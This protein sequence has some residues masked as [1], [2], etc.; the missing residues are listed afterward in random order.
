MNRHVVVCS[1]IL[2]ILLLVCLVAGG[3]AGTLPGGIPR[4]SYPSGFAPGTRVLLLAD[5]PGVAPELQAGMAGTIICCDADDCSGSLLVSWDLFTGGRD[6]EAQCVTA[7]VGLYPSGSTALVDPAQV[8]LGQPFDEIGILEEDA[9]GCLYLATED[10]RVFS[11]VIGPEFREQWKVVRAGNGVRI[12]GWVNMS[13]PDPKAERLCLQRDGDIYHPIMSVANWVDAPCCDRWVCGFGCGDRV[14]LI[15]K[16]NPYGAVDL[17]RGTTGTVICCRYYEEQSLLISWNLWE[18]G[19]SDD[20]YMECNER[21]SG[22]FPPGSTSWVS[23]LDVAKF[24]ESECGVLEEISLC[25]GN[26]CLD[27]DAV[28]LYAGWDRLYYL[29][30]ADVGRPLPSDLHRAIGLLTP[31]TAALSGQATGS[32]T[33]LDQGVNGI[34][35]SSVLIA[36]PEPSCCE[37]PYVR[38]DRVELLVDQPGGAMDLFAGATG[39][40]I[41]CNSDDPITPILVSWDY[42]AGGHDDDEGCD[43]PPEW[44]PDDSAWWMAC[45]EIKPIVLADLYDIGPGRF[46]P[47]S[48]QAGQ[49]FEVSSLIGNRGG[50]ESGPVF[51][52]VYL[53]ADDQITRDDFLLGLGG[54][55][56]DPGGEAGLSLRVSFPAEIPPGVYYVGWLIDPENNVKEA[57]ETNNTA[58]I[59]T[60][61]LTVP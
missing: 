35:L 58:V 8:L 1:A 31:Y 42:W 50:S 24:F 39:K 9:A 6:D 28:A 5:A 16:D 21:V 7:A 48:V 55:D 13:P 40:V 59:D 12:R 23:A 53:S 30:E 38:G 3:W 25:V 20:A 27:P 47:E 22:L 18:N 52:E 14:V 44:Y 19:G 49:A 4:P 33:V 34:I 57:D 41:C 29:P 51:V 2:G 32:E 17:P 46:S 37:P 60:G 54:M 56:I 26:V 15:S 11:L 45:T 36:C 10:G 61:Q 43:V